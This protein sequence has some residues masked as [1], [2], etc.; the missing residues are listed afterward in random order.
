MLEGRRDRV[1]VRS[2]PHECF[3]PRPEISFVTGNAPVWPVIST[4][5][6]DE[7]TDGDVLDRL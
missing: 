1:P 7:V 2:D 5:G 4:G 6:E 3:W